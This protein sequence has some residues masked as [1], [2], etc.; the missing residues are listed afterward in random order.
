VAPVAKQQ[1]G[2]VA[3]VIKARLAGRPA[4]KPFRYI[5]VGNLATVGRRAAVI[6]FGFL[7][8]SGWLAWWTWGI[9]H[10]YFLIGMRNRLIVAIHWLWSYITF[11]R[12]ARLITGADS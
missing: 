7:R 11:Q 3:R 10:I 2:Y 9:V 1:G 4:P 8:L 5:N 12:G 6:D